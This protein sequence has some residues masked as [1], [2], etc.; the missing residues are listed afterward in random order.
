M[1]FAILWVGK[2]TVIYQNMFDRHWYT[3]HIALPVSLNPQNRSH[4]TVV[5]AFFISEM[6]A[7]S[8]EPL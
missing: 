4:V 7:T 8:A 2:E 1:C 6:F 3:C 5:S